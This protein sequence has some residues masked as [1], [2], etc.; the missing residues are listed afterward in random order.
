MVKLTR[1]QKSASVFDAQDKR[2]RPSGGFSA[3]ARQ[4]G[5]SKQ[6]P[7]RIMLSTYFPTENVISLRSIC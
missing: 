4:Q 2:R 5:E 3:V 6:K 7:L 1:Q